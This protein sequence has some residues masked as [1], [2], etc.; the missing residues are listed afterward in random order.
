M[1]IIRFDKSRISEWNEFV[2]QA[3]NGVFLFERSYMSYHEDR[4]VD[5]SLMIFQNNKLIA[6]LPANERDNKIFSHGGLTFGGLLMTYEVKAKEAVLL[7]EEIVSYYKA[8]GIK[9]I[10]YKAIPYI[11]HKYPSQEDLYALFRNSF[12]L[13]RRD[14]S[15]VVDLSNPIRFSETKRQA[16]TKCSKAGVEICENQNFSEYWELLQNVLSKFGVKP[17]HTLQEIQILKSRFF[18]KIRLFEARVDGSLLAGIVIYD[19]CEVVH[20]Q[21]M[22]NS[23]EGRKLGALD[24]LNLKLITEY[25]SNRKYFSFGISNEN[26]GWYLNEGLVQ[27][28]EMMGGRGVTYDSYKISLT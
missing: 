2:S 10:T 22:A 17:V 19:Y 14:V 20:T 9:E 13:Y 4:F 15:S 1:N 18:E 6:L 26:D 23:G 5:H 27:Q 21:Y 3:K 28:K 12:S 16:L 24:F 8:C 25:F 7:I 11:F